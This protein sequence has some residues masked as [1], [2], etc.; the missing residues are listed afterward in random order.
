MLKNLA[1]S[2]VLSK[3]WG[4][5]IDKTYGTM[6]KMVFSFESSVEQLIEL[7]ALTGK[8]VDINKMFFSICIW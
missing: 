5:N 1:Q 7:Q 2:V 3:K 4:M 8:E 6:E